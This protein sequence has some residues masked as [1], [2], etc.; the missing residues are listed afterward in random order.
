MN[1]V[2]NAIEVASAQY[3]N[4]LVLGIVVLFCRI[5]SCLMIIPG[6]S[7]TQIPAQVRLMIALA[8]TLTLAPLLLDRLPLAKLD[9]EPL[10]TLRIFVIEVVIGASIGL[11]G[12]LFVLALETM[13]TAVSIGIGL[14]NPFGVAVDPNEMLPPLATF[15]TMAATASIFASDLHWEIIRGLVASYSVIPANGEFNSAVSLRGIADGLDQTFAI[16][17]RVCSPFIIY[18]IIVNFAV[19]TINRLTPQIG[20][21]YISTPFVLTGGFVLLFFALGSMLH[22]FS[23]SFGSWLVRG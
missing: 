7:S 21:F 9:G 5:G 13:L 10:M 15:V 11:V 17:L 19:A 1:F 8:V 2:Q 6:F 23:G 18:T 12:R 3:G 22:Q 16:T 14:A 20:I 4:Q